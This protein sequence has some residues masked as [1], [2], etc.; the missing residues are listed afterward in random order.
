MVKARIRKE[1]IFKSVGKE[2]QREALRGDL[3]FNP[4][5]GVSFR[6]HG[7]F[8]L[9]ER[10]IVKRRTFA[11][12]FSLRSFSERGKKERARDQFKEISKRG[13]H[14]QKGNRKSASLCALSFVSVRFR[15]R[16]NGRRERGG[17]GR[18]AS[19]SRR[20]R[21]ARRERRRTAS[22]VVVVIRNNEIVDRLFPEESS[23]KEGKID[24]K[25]KRTE[26]FRGDGP[27]AVFIE[28]SERFFEF[29]DLLVREFSRHDVFVVVVFLCRVCALRVRNKKSEEL[30]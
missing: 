15:S 28:Q 10:T 13:D 3:K 14:F 11:S 29:G 19:F 23:A 27:V 17:G 20:T 25:L 30:V 16:K 7:L 24:Q 26:L 12:F 22:V 18:T 8:A 2:D 6:S 1:N 21:F 4:P 5:P 9:R